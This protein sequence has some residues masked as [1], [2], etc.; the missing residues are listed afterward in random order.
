[1]R[2]TSRNIAVCAIVII[3]AL[4]SGPGLLA[5]A[6]GDPYLG[7]WEG[8]WESPD[9]MGGAFVM[10]LEHKDDG[11]LGG[12]I[13]VELG[14]S[15]LY[16]A[17]LKEVKIEDGKLVARYENL[18]GMPG[19]IVLEGTLEGKSGS[20]TYSMVPQGSTQSYTGGSW[21]AEHK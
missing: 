2:R 16:E 9:G 1:M 18:E 19:T 21:K 13:S 3:L 5:A 8:T 15:P 20:G 12:Q 10:T 11:K 7:R 14:G 4:V 6:S 17:P